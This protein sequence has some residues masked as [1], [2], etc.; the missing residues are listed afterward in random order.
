VWRQASIPEFLTEEEIIK[1]LESCNKSTPIGLQDYTIL[2]LMLTLGLRAFEVSGLTLEDFDWDR[3]V[4]TIYG[5]GPKISTLPLTQSLGDIL[6]TYLLKGRPYCLLRNFF[7]SIEEPFCALTA[8]E[9]SNIIGA[10]LKQAGL[11]KKGKARLLRHT[12][13]TSLL[14][15]GASLQEIGEILRHQSINTT[16]IYAKVDFNRL[17]SLAL[18]WP[19]KWR[20]GGSL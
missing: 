15:K 13:A 20:F 1:L 17:H 12:L 8:V 4:V 14:N 6:V 10:A 2:S 9:I 5:K 18:P 3:G 16:Q 11:R 19:K 7:V